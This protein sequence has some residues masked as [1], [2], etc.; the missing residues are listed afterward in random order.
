MTLKQRVLMELKRLPESDPL[1]EVI[2]RLLENRR[3]TAKNDP[4]EPG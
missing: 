3:N 4:L 2:S 1:W